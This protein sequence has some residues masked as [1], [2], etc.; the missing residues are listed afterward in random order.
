MMFSTN[1][2]DVVLGA[3]YTAFS[4]DA[5]TLPGDGRVLFLRARDGGQ[6]RALRRSAWVCEQTFKPYADALVR[7]GL[8]VVDPL[9]DEATADSQYALVVVLPPRQRDEA[10]A[11]FA[12]AV[13]HVAP[14]GIVLA[15]VMNAEGARSSETDLVRLTGATQSLSKHKCRVFWTAPLTTQV[16][17]DLQAEWAQLDALQAIVDGHFVSRPGL[18]AWNRIDPASVLLAAHLPPT[19]A[20]KIADLGAGYGYLAAEILRR[21]AQVTAL[22]LYEAEARALE[23]ARINIAKAISECVDMVT[24]NVIWHDVCVGLPKRYDAIVS[25][26]PFHLGR[27]DRPEL[28]RAF[29]NVAADA[30]LPGG[31]FWLVANRHLAYET[32]LAARFAMVR[33]VIVQDGFKVIEASD[34]IEQK[35]TIWANK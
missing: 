29:I 18:F 28:G 5:V 27:A 21:C 33:T 24:T 26:P 16:D 3:L 7:G 9:L 23:P 14:G 6:P 4:T 8:N 12:R 32:T 20:G 25:N 34:P 22:D 2:P 31:R 30:L 1:A 10:R 15:S 11:L 17:Q 19:L 35:S 13:R